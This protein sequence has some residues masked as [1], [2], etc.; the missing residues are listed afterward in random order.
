M[1]AA[2]RMREDVALFWVTPITFV[3]MAEEIDTLP[4]PLPELV[5]VPVLFTDAVV[6]VMLPEFCRRVRL[7]VPVM[8][9]EWVKVVAPLF[10]K[11]RPPAPSVVAPEIVALPAPVPLVIVTAAVPC[12]IGPESVIALVPDTLSIVRLLFKDT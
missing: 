2:D 11:L 5:I 6:I 8:P 3:P 1:F 4:D 10:T 7:P 12:V 9:P